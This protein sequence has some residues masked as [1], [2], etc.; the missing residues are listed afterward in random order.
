MS[1][2]WFFLGGVVAGVAGLVTTALVWDSLESS[3]DN[4]EDAQDD[5]PIILALPEV[6]DTNKQADK[7]LLVVR[8]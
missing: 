8:K 2:M 4:S 3:D 7:K 6:P 5:E 1:K